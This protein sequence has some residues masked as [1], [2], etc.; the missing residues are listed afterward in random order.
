VFLV[1]GAL[2]LSWSVVVYIFLPDTPM[3]ARF[4]NEQDRT[5]AVER[6]QENKTG[7]KNN[8]WK[9]AQAVEATLDIKIW[10]LVLIQLSTNV[11]N[12]GVQSVG[13]YMRHGVL[14]STIIH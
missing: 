14:L 3:V 9:L 7:I 13:L 4:L 11:A 1:F 5:K 12:G 6:I 10:L 2:T 8:V